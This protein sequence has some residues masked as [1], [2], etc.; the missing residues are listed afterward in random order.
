MKRVARTVD[1]KEYAALLARTLPRVIH[2]ELENEQYTTILEGLL[3]KTDR[4]IEESRLMELL[5]LLIEDFEARHYVLPAASPVEIIR[6]LMDA[7]GLL[8]KDMV[9]VFG[10]A[11]IA[12]DVLSGKRGLAKRHIE[13]LS[14]RF[15][16]SPEVFF[17]LRELGQVQDQA[18]NEMIVLKTD[19]EAASRNCGELYQRIR[20]S[21]S[22]AK[23]KQK[24]PTRDLPIFTSPQYSDPSPQ[25]CM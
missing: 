1:K 13:K 14:D 19:G 24:G 6:H 11:S 5:V 7:N 4:S 8:Q 12:S 17:P 15:N 25:Y 22:G 10:T 23:L 2:T 9:D 18:M 20:G 3:L 16:V 21:Q